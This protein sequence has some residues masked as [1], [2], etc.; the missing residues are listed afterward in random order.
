MK[1]AYSKA[2]GSI[3]TLCRS[4]SMNYSYILFYSGEHVC[5]EIHFIRHAE[6]SMNV[7]PE[8]IVGRSPSATLTG[9]GKRQARALGVHLRSVGMDFDA[10]YCSPLE[11]AKQT[12]YALCQVMKCCRSNPVLR[13]FL[14]FAKRYYRALL[15]KITVHNREVHY[16]DF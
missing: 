6:S 3:Y 1:H 5:T 15:Q 4:A 11:R 12:A 14:E 13:L 16:R 2:A 9:L 7:R 8:L 10:V